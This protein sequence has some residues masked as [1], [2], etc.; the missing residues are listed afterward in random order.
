MAPQP[1]APS[2]IDIL[3]TRANTA[4]CA[5]TMTA[6]QTSDKPADPLE[7]T[8]R[9]LLARIA[10]RD[11]AALAALYD[12]ALGKVYGLALRIV[13]QAEAAEEVAE[14]TFWQVWNEASRFDPQRGRALTWMLT[15]CRSRALDHLRRRDE[16][17]PFED[18]EAL[19]SEALA[20]DDDPSR[21]L[22]AF[23]RASAVRAAVETLNPTQRQMVALAFFRGLTHQEIADACRMPL[24]TVKT[25]L[26]KAC[27]QLMQKL[28]PELLESGT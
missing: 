5:R 17:E 14:D 25:H 27:R 22:D 1:S 2:G 19:R 4:I 11:E 24:G 8:C 20:D 13:R 16:A 21:L 23:E 3:A 9:E 6:T 18:P 28:S 12:A 15:I 26:H 7:A 10:G